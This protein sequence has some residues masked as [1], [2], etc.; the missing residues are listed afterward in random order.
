MF[1]EQKKSAKFGFFKK[2]L[3]RFFLR[4]NPGK[5]T[6]FC[7]SVFVFLQRKQ[8]KIMCAILWSKKSM[9]FQDQC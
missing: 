5:K 4:K 7:G 8:K 2:K 9:L 1:V 3:A 6:F